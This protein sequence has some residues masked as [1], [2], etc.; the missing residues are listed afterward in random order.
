MPGVRQYT[1]AKSYPKKCV[2]KRVALMKM[3]NENNKPCSGLEVGSMENE[4]N[5][6]CSGLEVGSGC[7]VKQS[8]HVTNTNVKCQSNDVTLA[9][10]LN[11]NNEK[12]NTNTNTGYSISV[13]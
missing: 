2:K 8:S 4:N 5:K 11:H 9:C 13:G 7:R 1:D 6:P 10:L 3:K 12:L